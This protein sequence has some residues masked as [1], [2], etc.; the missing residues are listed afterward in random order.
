VQ[1]QL[2]LP[3]EQEKPAQEVSTSIFQTNKELTS[4]LLKQA[5]QQ[6]V[7]RGVKFYTEARTKKHKSNA[8]KFM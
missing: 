1:L 7:L 4:H 6:P 3:W 8:Q 5:N 2:S